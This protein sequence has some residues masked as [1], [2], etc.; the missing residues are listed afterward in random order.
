[1]V[2]SGVVRGV[3]VLDTLFFVCGFSGGFMI[4]CFWWL[5]DDLFPDGFRWFGCGFLLC[6]LLGFCARFVIS[7]VVW[8]W[9]MAVVMFGL[10]GDV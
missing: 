8:L 9:R 3:C 6:G 7:W 5:V 1:M 10:V 2:L 4:D